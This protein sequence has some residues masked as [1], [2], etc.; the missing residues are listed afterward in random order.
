MNGIRFLTLLSLLAGAACATKIDGLRSDPSFTA[1]ALRDKTLVMAVVDAVDKPL[2]LETSLAF[3]QEMRIGFL[4][5]RPW[6]STLDGGAL[7]SAIGEGAYERLRTAWRPGA[8]VGKDELDLIRD[9]LP[10]AGYATFAR[11]EENR[12]RS[13]RDRQ[14]LHETRTLDD[15]STVTVDTGYEVTATVERT[16]TVSL[17]IYDL[18]AG[19]EVWGGRVTKRLS[20]TRVF[21]RRVAPGMGIVVDLMSMMPPTGEDRFYPFPAPP[22]ERRLLRSIFSGFAEHLPGKKKG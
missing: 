19:G 6:L 8:S 16:M 22:D 9:A 1:V 14:T 2:S 12:L 15:G 5:Q 17:S 7:R 10:E 13:W 18:T 20:E 4:D 11:I 21:H 3:T